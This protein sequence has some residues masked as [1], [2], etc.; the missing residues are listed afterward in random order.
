M[1]M[2][3]L[4]VSHPRLT[5]ELGAAQTALHLAAALREANIARSYEEAVLEPQ[6]DGV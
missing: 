3:I 4:L 2:R 6:L 1:S 5:A